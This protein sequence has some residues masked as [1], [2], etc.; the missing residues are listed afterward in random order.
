MVFIYQL[1]RFRLLFRQRFQ[2]L[3][4]S[5]LLS[6]ICTILATSIIIWRLH[7][8]NIF[9]SS[10]RRCVPV[11]NGIKSNANIAIVTFHFN[12]SNSSEKHRDS[13]ARITGPFSRR[14]HA[15][16]AK[17]QGYKLIREDTFSINPNLGKFALVWAKVDVLK[18]HLHDFDWLVWIDSDLLIMNFKIRLETFIPRNDDIDIVITS[19]KNGIN[20][21]IFFWRNSPSGHE[22]LDKWA[23]LASSNAHEQKQLAFLIATEPTIAKRTRILPLCAV[24][25]Y[26]TANSL[27]T[28]YEYGDFGIH[29]AGSAWGLQKHVSVEYGWNLFGYFSDLAGDDGITLKKWLEWR[30]LAKLLQ[31][32]WRP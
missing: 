3:K 1:P 2:P 15:A 16:Y 19:D 13:K 12:S 5:F 22:T 23:K 9:G 17:Y 14:N 4:R 26:L 24:N 20:A 25:S 7:L 18:K 27:T 11:E 29:F 31:L 8:L 32:P 10:I 21:G 30:N 6:F 28:R